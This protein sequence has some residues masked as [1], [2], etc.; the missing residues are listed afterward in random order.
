MVRTHVLKAFV[1][2]LNVLVL[3]LYLKLVCCLKFAYACHM[4][5]IMKFPNLQSID[6]IQNFINVEAFY[7]PNHII[8]F[9]NNIVVKYDYA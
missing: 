5:I 7:H 6:D 2:S 8:S 1:A 4:I 3:V 9:N